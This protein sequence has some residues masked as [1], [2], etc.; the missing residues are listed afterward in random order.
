MVL[1]EL[2]KCLQEYGWSI[3]EYTKS[4]CDK[5]ESNIAK[6]TGIIETQG[7]KIDSLVSKV[8]NLEA[9]GTNSEAIAKVVKD[10]EKD[11]YTELAER[12]NRRDNLIIH[13]I[14]EAG[15]NIKNSKDRK[16]FDLDK[17][18][19]LYNVLGINCNI[20]RATKFSSRLGVRK[21]NDPRPLII[22]FVKT[23]LYIIRK[24]VK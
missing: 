10:R 19:D 11:I 20:D 4:G 12:E 15:P 22:G 6:N 2:L 5:N 13:N 1:Q 18:V 9:N 16:N 24:K 7:E 14:E 3:D 21:G 23:F 8:Q 17:I